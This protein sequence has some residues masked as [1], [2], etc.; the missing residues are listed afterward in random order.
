MK[1]SK[2]VLHLIAA[3]LRLDFQ[4][5]FNHTIGACPAIEHQQPTI[6]QCF[7]LQGLLQHI[8]LCHGVGNGRTGKIHYAAAIVQLI[9][10]LTFLV[11]IHGTLAADPGDTR[12][13]AHFGI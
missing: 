7:R 8:Q 12:H 9:D 6:F 13:I 3:A 5:G 11:H 1:L 2:P 10:V 4:R